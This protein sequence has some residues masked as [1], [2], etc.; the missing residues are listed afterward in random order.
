MTENEQT[1]GEQ[2]SVRRV[3]KKRNKYVVKE[4]DIGREKE[5]RCAEKSKNKTNQDDQFIFSNI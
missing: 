1:D 2:S 5:E 3:Q 4:E